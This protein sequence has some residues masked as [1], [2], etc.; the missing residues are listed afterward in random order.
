[1]S[2][3]H[4][5]LKI[6]EDR[7]RN[8]GGSAPQTK[9]DAVHLPP[10]VATAETPP[11]R[12]EK[13][14]N[15]LIALLIA[16][17]L[18]VAILIALTASGVIRLP[19]ASAMGLPSEWDSAAAAAVAVSPVRPQADPRPFADG[20]A[21]PSADGAAEAPVEADAAT[22]SAVEPPGDRPAAPA[23][24]TE[25]GPQA[26]EELNQAWVQ[27][28]RAV[29]SLAA[30][31]GQSGSPDESLAGEP[32]PSPTGQPHLDPIA[33]TASAAAGPTG[34][35][36]GGSPVA[37][38][39]AATEVLDLSTLAAEPACP[40][41]GS[42]A[43][44]APQAAEPAPAPTAAA[45]ELPPA[46]GPH[47]PLEPVTWDD[48]PAGRAAAVRRPAARPARR[49]YTVSAIMLG[50]GRPSAI[51][52]GK[53]VYVGDR[54]DGAEVLSITRLYLVLNVDGQRRTVRL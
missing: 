17:S 33:G 46:A 51:L 43:P 36:E 29:E 42:E 13:L 38:P 41:G 28:A 26:L 11:R 45:A 23:A 24:A 25:T 2:L 32:P 44:A 16:A 12:R 54:I 35:G 20:V 14:L 34:L 15:V 1:M 6:T 49:G 19:F 52:N 27:R 9:S 22:A 18:G 30:P 39:V 47:E 48:V 21:G 8:P 7:M 31:G 37:D 40:A 10:P 3:I 50:G 5:A 53:L 4:E